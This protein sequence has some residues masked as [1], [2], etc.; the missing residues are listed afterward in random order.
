MS[1]DKTEAKEEHKTEAI[2]SQSKGSG[3]GMA[4]L[5]NWAEQ[6]SLLRTYWVELKSPEEISEIL[7]RSVA[8]IMT[9][10]ARLGLPRRAAPGRKR[11]FKRTDLSAKDRTVRIKVKRSRVILD[12]A[13]EV[14]D[15]PLEVKLRVC[16]MCLK[17]FESQGKHNRI[18]PVCKGSAEYATGASTP[19]FT[20]EVSQ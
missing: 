13:D 6:D 18:C 1:T 12:E 3:G 14:K 19:D 8:A 5:P 4:V 15:G 7:G 11:G 9:R 17:K 10:A 16:L 20:F 2:D